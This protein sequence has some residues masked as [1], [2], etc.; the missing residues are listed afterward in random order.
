MTTASKDNFDMAPPGPSERLSSC[1]DTYGIE[2]A[3]TAILC[4]AFGLHLLAIEA[5]PAI[6]SRR[7]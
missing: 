5:A 4:P 3:A 6:L 2:P 1:L 7:V